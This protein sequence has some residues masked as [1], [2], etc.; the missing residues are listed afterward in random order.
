M[1]LNICPADWNYFRSP[2]SKSLLDAHGGSTFRLSRSLFPMHFSDTL[3][4]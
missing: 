2:F 3:P 4:H 1:T